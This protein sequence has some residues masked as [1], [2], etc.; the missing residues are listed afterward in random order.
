V[1][2]IASALVL[3]IACGNVASLL[4]A[5]AAIRRREISIRLALGANRGRLI[6]QLL[7]ESLLLS[8]AGGAGGLLAAKFARD[9]VWAMRPPMFN[10]SGVTLALDLR[11][12]GFTLAASLFT[13]IVFGLVPAL[14]STRSNLV[15][16]LKERAGRS[17]Q[18]GRWQLRTLLLSG[19]VAFSVMA[20]LGAGLFVRSVR[21]AERIDPGFDAERLGTVVFNVGDQG[22]PE[23]RGREYQQRAREIAALT[24]GVISAAL[25]RDPPLR[26]SGSRTVLLDAGEMQGLPTLTSVVQPGYF[27]TMGIPL[28]RGR[29]FTFNDTPESPRAAVINEAAAAHFWPNEHAIGKTLHFLGDS[30]Q[31][32]VVGVVRNANYQNIGETPRAMIY[33]SLVQYYFPTAVVYIRTSGDPEAVSLA[34]RKQMQSLDRNL[35]LQSESFTRSIRESL[36]AHHLIGGLLG[37]FGVLAVLLST[38]GIYGVISYSVN[39]RTREFGV[40]SALGAT[41]VQIQAM[42]LAEGMRPVALGVVAGVLFGLGASHMVRSMLYISP[43]DAVTFVLVPAILTVAGALASWI[44]CLRAVRVDPAVALRDE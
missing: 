42:V 19:Q 28:R 27:Q 23:V 40:R 5:R 4:L 20:L 6:R 12:L 1:L 22:Y 11:V 13:G 41:A 8:L 39:Q 38:M 16:D 31:A 33:L 30:R 43:Y 32:E 34:V 7:T 21:D 29:D 35:V 10:R 26:V 17:F 24:P 18:P 37:A 9:A 3:L 25:S 44:P 2:L 14:R 15:S 36:W